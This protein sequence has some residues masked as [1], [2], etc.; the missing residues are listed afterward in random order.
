MA[1]AYSMLRKRLTPRA[2]AQAQVKTKAMLHEMHLQ[3][4]REVRHMTQEEVAKQLHVKQSSVSKLERQADMYISTL[5]NYL[6]AIGGKL[7]IKATFSDGEVSIAQ[8]ED[9]A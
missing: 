3:E 6:S 8:F 4:L 2:R 7:E 1:K 9:I 5:R